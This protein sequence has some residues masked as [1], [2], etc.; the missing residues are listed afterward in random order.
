MSNLED[1]NAIQSYVAN[2]A[3]KT[4]E[5]ATLKSSFA[6]WFDGLG[7]AEKNVMTGDDTLANARAKR[8]VFNRANK[9]VL[10][11][12]PR[13]M[14][15]QDEADIK[16]LGSVDVTGMTPQQ[17][18]SA[19]WKDAPYVPPYKPPTPT[20]PASSAGKKL[21]TLK[22]YANNDPVYV[23][24]WQGI[25][26]LGQDGKF[27]GGTEAA[28][29]GW[30]TSH[31]LQTTGVVDAAT[32]AKALGTPVVPAAGPSAIAATMKP[33]P[34]PATQTFAQTVAAIPP[35][36]EPTQLSIAGMLSR[37]NALP[38]WAKWGLG[39]AAVVG[40][41]LNIA[42]PAKPVTKK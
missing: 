20:T 7:W 2:T 18:H 36:Q 29:K 3:T 9:D 25:L 11:F 38:S 10:A 17:A 40:I 31:G 16:K 5:A 24:Q 22:R 27:A 15:A 14:T 32:W 21:P 4:L 30:Q 6:S 1:L 34:A 33:K 39:V 23:K 12:V 35:A 37:W 28:T 8:E 41:G 13:E 19:A 42:I 26:G